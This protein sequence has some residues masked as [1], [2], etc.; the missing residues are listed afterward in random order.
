MS[1]ESCFE[2]LWVVRT[3]CKH[4]R[5][6]LT[7]SAVSE[8]RVC[9]VFTKSSLNSL[10]Y[11]V[12]DRT[13]PECCFGS[14]VCRVFTKSSLNSLLYIVQDRTSPDNECCFGNSL[15][16]GGLQSVRG[17]AKYV[18]V[19]RGGTFPD[20][21]AEM[22][23]YLESRVL[24]FLGDYWMKYVC[25][26]VLCHACDCTY[27]CVCFVVH[28]TVRMRMRALSCNCNCT[29]TCVCFVVQ[30]QLYVYVCVLCRA[31]ATVRIRVCALSYEVRMRMRALSCME[32][33]IYVCVLCRA[34][35]TVRM[36]MRALSCME[37]HIYVCVLCRAIATVRIRVC[38]LSCVQLQ[39]KKCH[40]IAYF[41]GV[42]WLGLRLGLLGCLCMSFSFPA[43]GC[44]TLQSAAA[45]AAEKKR[46][47]DYAPFRAAL[48]GAGVNNLQVCPDR[49]VGARE[50]F[51]NA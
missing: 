27:T 37:L 45:D 32:L 43:Q 25:A 40:S 49:P 14:R 41:V 50:T 47:C 21:I 31:I 19:V 11:I 5:C 30:L 29:Y 9:R 36:R 24:P 1:P 26:C 44:V 20:G 16:G 8:I 2:N 33:H 23:W 39:V 22:R 15:G 46:I 35:A 28:A 7:M 17:G 4:D 6:H 10:L 51:I 34:I 42:L 13:S 12:L 38:A 3:L 48:A 18:N